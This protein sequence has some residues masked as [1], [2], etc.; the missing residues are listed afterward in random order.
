MQDSPVHDGMNHRQST[1]GPL[2][3]KSHSGDEIAPT[4]FHDR[5]ALDSQSIKGL[6]VFR[7]AV[8]LRRAMHGATGAGEL[9]GRIQQGNER[10][11]KLAARR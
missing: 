8:Q 7:R 1:S 3:L 11:C 6:T 5:K 9:V 10:T 4:E 2:V